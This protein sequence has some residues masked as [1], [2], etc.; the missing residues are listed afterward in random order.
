VSYLKA[1]DYQDGHAGYS[2]PSDEQNWLVSTINH[3][4]SLPTWRSTAVVITYD[5]SDG[6]YDHVLGPVLTQSQTA[7]DTLTGPGQCGASLAQV[8]Q[9]SAGQPE[10][11]R[12]GVGARMPF[13]LVSPWAWANY[14]DSSLLDQSPVMKFIEDNWSLPAMGN[15]ASDAAAGSI[16][17]MFNFHSDQQRPLF[18]SSKTGAVRCR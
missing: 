9:N 2:D 4:M 17:L 14:V 18:L 6:W 3:L 1:P 12:C 10:Q 11:G 16:N 7:L 15:G 8:P 5:D 13:L